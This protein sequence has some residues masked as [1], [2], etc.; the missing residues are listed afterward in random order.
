MPC[1]VLAA[2]LAGAPAARA[3][4]L[5]AGPQTD[6]AFADVAAE[7]A[8]ALHGGGRLQLIAV[9]GPDAALDKLLETPDALAV[10]DLATMTDYA[11][12]HALPPGRLTF[13]GEVTQR[14]VVVFVQKGGWVHSLGELEGAGGTPPP[15]LGLAGADAAAAFAVMLRLDGA[16]AGVTVVPGAAGPLASQVA[17]GTLDGVLV[18]AYPDLAPEALQRLADD[19]RLV[20]VAVVTRRLARA[21][22]TDE[23]GYA[24][25]PPP[26]RDG[27][28]PWPARPE[29]ALCTPL[30]AVARDDTPAP[31]RDALP[32]A[33]RAAKQALHRP[34][35]AERAGLVARGAL[36]AL[37]G[38][39]A[40][41]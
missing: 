1:V 37:R 4:T 39:L 5:Y 35:L 6:P 11:V 32:G 30:G 20:R 29:P 8:T 18:V 40:N 10:T 34:D 19:D 15:T 7:L 22:A 9:S 17:R 27:L 26:G 25:S 12:R 13:A 23:G 24:L 38:W 21:V 28:L 3:Q 16:L 33:T 14:C 31:L 36:D 2:S 41:P